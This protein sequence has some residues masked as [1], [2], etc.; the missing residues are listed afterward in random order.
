[1]KGLLLQ[2]GP[3]GKCVGIKLRGQAS[4]KFRFQDVA[5]STIWQKPTLVNVHL[6]GGSLEVQCH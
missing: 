5:T 1:M 6:L 3:F 4:L 2:P